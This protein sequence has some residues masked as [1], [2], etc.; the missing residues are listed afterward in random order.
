MQVREL[1]CEASRRADVAK[2]VLDSADA[3]AH[4]AEAR[5]LAATAYKFP[6][7]CR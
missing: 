4:P 5:S 3:R 2:L 7:D 1:L 6:L